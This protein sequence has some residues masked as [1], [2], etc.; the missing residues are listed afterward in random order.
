VAR[1]KLE[2]GLI[3]FLPEEPELKAH[4]VGALLG[5][6][7]ADSP[8]LLGVKDDARQMRAQALHYLAQFFTTVTQETPAV[9][10]LDD[11]HWADRPSLKA[12][13]HIISQCP[14]LRLLVVCLARPRLFETWPDWG[15]EQATGEAQAT[16]LRLDPLPK[17]ASYELVAEMLQQ[18]EAL[19][20]AFQEQI[21]SAA[22]GNPFYLEELVEMAID[23][24]VIRREK[25]TGTWRLDPDKL[26]TMRV[27][28]TLTSVLQARLDSLP[29]AEKLVLRQA[30]VIGR[31]FWSAALQALQGTGEAPAAELAALSRRDIIHFQ[32][33]PA[34]SGTEEYAFKHGLM[35]DVAYEM[36]VKRTR[37]AYH[38]QVAE[39]LGDATESSGRTGEYAGVIGEHYEL[40][41]ERDSAADWYLQAGERAKAQGAPSE[42]RRFFD[43]TLVLLPEKDA[44]RRWTALLSR[45]EVLATLGETEARHADDASLVALA[46]DAQDGS[47]LAAAYQRQA[48]T[49][50]TSGQYP[51]ALETY[52][53]ALDAAKRAG[54]L[55]AEA[56]T[57]G[58]K[59]AC[60]TRLDQMDA[61]ARSAEAALA[62]ARDIG[63][64]DTL[65][66]NLNNAAFFHGECG[67]VARATELLE[68]QVAI[69]HRLGNHLGEAVGLSNLGYNY[70]QLGRP[71]RA[72][73]A[74]KRSVELAAAVGHRRHAA[75]GRLNLALAHI[76]HGEPGTAVQLLGECRPSLKTLHDRF[77]QAACH[78]YA[79]LANESSGEHQGAEECFFQA[80]EMFRAIGIRGCANDAHAGVARCSLALG[81]LAA[82]Q[83][84]AAMVWTYLDNQGPGAMEFP[85][86][87]YLTCADVFEAAGRLEASRRAMEDG[88]SE[89]VRRADRLGDAEWRRSFLEHVPEH[90]RLTE[91]WQQASNT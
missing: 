73:S 9:V 43:K 72:I 35:R 5:Y 76:Y 6:D 46:Q 67:E 82:A 22:E 41:G 69:N 78:L 42:A 55:Q 32:E 52:A 83:Q 23:Q 89:L 59:A 1:L 7:L 80:G 74:L 85:V 16:L 44:E 91:R 33:K 10:L 48:N 34:F 27:P 37:R 71:E 31:N 68:E 45:D 65:V 64:E 70:V 77:G 29:L 25:K 18:V 26:G 81:Q 90:R 3:P 86:L 61:A 60:L 87:A 47:K 49:F 56:L 79:A 11:I 63:D 24:S 40:A 36:V 57:L 15:Q 14:T 13:T 84:H 17:Q 2:T 30:A 20:E 54:D 19:P 12:I 21:V 8:H 38:G 51:K 66:R 50:Y 39:W 28:A 4:F 62:R 58:M 75:Y 53:K 88:Y